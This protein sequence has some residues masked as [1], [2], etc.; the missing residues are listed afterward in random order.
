ME[1]KEIAEKFLELYKEGKTEEIIPIMTELYDDNEVLK[2]IADVQIQIKELGGGWPSVGKQITTMEEIFDYSRIAIDFAL[3]KGAKL[4]AGKLNHNVASFCFPNMDEGVD[5]KYIEP[6]YKA[7]NADLK[8]RKDIG[9]KV[10][11]MWSMWMVGVSKFVRGDVDQSIKTLEELYKIAKEDPP[12]ESLA[13]W[14]DLMKIKFQIK[15]GKVSKE[16]TAEEIK[17]IEN[18]LTEQNDSYGLSILEIVKNL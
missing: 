14:A 6:G 7:A 8:L 11:M 5:S 10:P 16:Y 9:D 13:V 12:N 3:D 17:R 2:K 1:P 18:I 15:S 4:V